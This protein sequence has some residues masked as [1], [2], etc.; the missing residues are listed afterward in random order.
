MRGE[1]IGLGERFVN[2]DLPGD[3]RAFE[4]GDL[5]YSGGVTI[6]SLRTSAGKSKTVMVCCCDF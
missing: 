5:V 4:R 1:G 6:T 2:L 3:L